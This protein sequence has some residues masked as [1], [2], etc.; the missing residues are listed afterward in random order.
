M[1]VSDNEIM[2]IDSK[3]L[4]SHSYLNIATTTT[5][6]TPQPSISIVTAYVINATLQRHTASKRLPPSTA[7]LASSAARHEQIHCF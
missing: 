1:K 2:G 4:E 3:I 5:T 7:H 6:T